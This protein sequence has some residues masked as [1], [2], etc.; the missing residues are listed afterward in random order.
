[1]GTNV[2][3]RLTFDRRGAAGH[4]PEVRAAID[5][6][7]TPSARD[8]RA[9]LRVVAG[10]MFK[11]E[12][13][14]TIPCFDRRV[15]RDFTRGRR[16]PNNGNSKAKKPALLNGKSSRPAALSGS[17]PALLHAHAVTLLGCP[18][19]IKKWLITGRRPAFL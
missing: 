10:D 8:L 11:S 15:P 4:V 17:T 19:M 13:F 3:L 1:M 9:G 18:E 12:S 7:R 14:R 5:Q 16:S 2:G 6:D